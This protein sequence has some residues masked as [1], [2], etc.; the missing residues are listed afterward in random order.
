MHD[1]LG[2]HAEEA[3]VVFVTT[4]AL[5]LILCI[6]LTWTKLS[7]NWTI[8]AAA[9]AG[10]APLLAFI[11]DPE[12]NFDAF[13]CGFATLLLSTAGLIAIAAAHRQFSDK[14]AWARSSAQPFFSHGSLNGVG[15]PKYFLRVA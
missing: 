8:A 10:F 12:N 14:K 3:R 4:Q 13:D 11:Q 1:H 6:A 2:A 15:S 9:I 5:F 7:D